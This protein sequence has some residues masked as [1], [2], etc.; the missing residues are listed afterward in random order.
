MFLACFKIR[1]KWF[2]KVFPNFLAHMNNLRIKLAYKFINI[3]HSDYHFLLTTS[4]VQTNHIISPHYFNLSDFSN[5]WISSL[6]GKIVN[7]FSIFLWIYHHLNLQWLP[8]D[9]INCPFGIY[10]ASWI[11]GGCKSRADSISYLLSQC[12]DISIII[13]GA[14]KVFFQPVKSL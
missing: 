2:R 5:K 10:S 8:Y 7:S 1:I 6:C 3:M 9:L 13:I 12:S 14:N 4:T 11:F